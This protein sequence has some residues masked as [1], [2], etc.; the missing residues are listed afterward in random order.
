MPDIIHVWTDDPVSCAATLKGEKFKDVKKVEFVFNEEGKEIGRAEAKLDAG[1]G[2]AE[3]KWE[4]AKGPEKPALVRK[5]HYHVELDGKPLT[6]FPEEIHVWAKEV[7]VLAKD[8]DD[9][10]YEGAMAR[11]QNSSEKNDKE[12]ANVLRKTDKDGKIVWRL[13]FPGP[14]QVEWEPPYFLLDKKW[15]K[16]TGI[17]WEAKVERISPIKL[18]WP[19]PGEPHKQ[20]V[21]LD[22]DDKH[23]EYGPTV[24]VKV[25]ADGAMEKGKKVHL[26]AEYHKDN[27]T[28][29]PMTGAKAPNEKLEVAKDPDAKG[30]AEFDLPVGYAGGDI[31]TVS[32]GSTDKCEDGKVVIETWRKLQYEVMAPESMKARLEEESKCWKLKTATRTWATQ[33]LAAIHVVYEERAGHIYPD[34]SVKKFLVDGPFIG[35]PA[36]KYYICSSAQAFDNPEPATFGKS[37]KRSIFMRVCDVAARSEAAAL[38]EQTL[39][40]AEKN[41][42]VPGDILPMDPGDGSA[43]IS[44]VSW[45]AVVD[46]TAYPKH[47]G[48]DGSGKPKKG[49]FSPSAIELLTQTTYKVV[50]SGDARKLAGPAG[51]KNCPIKV[52]WKWKLAVILNGSARG[53]KQLMCLA[54]PANAVACTICHELGHTMGMTILGSGDYKRDP[55]EGMPVPDP[56]GTGAGIYYDGHGHRGGHCAHGLSDSDR[57]LGSYDDVQGTCIMFGA[58]GD[59]ENPARDAFCPQCIK[60]LKGR[61]LSDIEA[62]WDGRGKDQ[63]DTAMED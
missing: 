48:L 14:V 12:A 4:K 35:K 8:K 57:A 52:S 31:I 23:P 9:H 39:Q 56:V 46:K 6:N 5:L 42:V 21:N 61:N 34:K 26:K 10:P 19:P 58:G 27:S 11:I 51:D 25:V 29:T 16:N 7:E 62:G 38:A 47:P 36:G 50:L 43:S 63:S 54:R 59:E 32:V 28:R 3:G 30:G 37:D 45:Q 13:A 17:E 20:W 44:D 22:A 33:R 60:Y 2:K 49:T 53:M 15:S 24:K 18:S 55:P 41:F 40:A 1:S